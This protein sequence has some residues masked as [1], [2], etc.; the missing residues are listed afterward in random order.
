MKFK[1]KCLLIALIFCILDQWTKYLVAQH[2][3]IGQFKSL[4]NNLAL[5]YLLNPG[6][7]FSFLANM[8]GAQVWLFTGLSTIISAAIIF[9]ILRV[10]TTDKLQIFSLSLVLG[11][12]VGNLIDRVRLG[13]VVDFI[14]FHVGN[15]SWPA[16]NLADTVICIGAFL[17]VVQLFFGKKTTN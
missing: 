15:W 5:Y 12:A 13:H 7:A 8:G 2:M 14:F 10:S 1:I 3:H 9:Y 16:F 17:F 6:A 4:L 11:G